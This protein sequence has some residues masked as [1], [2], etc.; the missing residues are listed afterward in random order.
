MEIQA[1][2]LF[3]ELKGQEP[4][5]TVDLPGESSFHYVFCKSGRLG[6]KGVDLGLQVVERDEDGL[7]MGSDKARYEVEEFLEG[8]GGCER[9]RGSRC[10]AS[11]NANGGGGGSYRHRWWWSFEGK[12]EKARCVRILVKSA[13]TAVQMIEGV[14]SDCFLPLCG[15]SELGADSSF[16]ILFSNSIP[17]GWLC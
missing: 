8:R 6:P 16:F 3:R 10:Y 4:D 5:T 9:L 11:E 1:K 14:G 12:V 7:E 15:S 17:S 13:I 2:D